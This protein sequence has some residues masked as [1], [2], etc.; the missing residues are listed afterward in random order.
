MSPVAGL[1]PDRGTAV[2][3]LLRPGDG[4]ALGVARLAGGFRWT[5]PGPAWVAVEGGAGVLGLDGRRAEVAGRGDLFDGPGWSA[6]A[7]PGAAVE[8]AGGLRVALVWR[9][10]GE[11]AAR[12][13]APDEV[14]T[15]VRG[16]GADRRVVRTAVADGPLRCGETLNDPGCWSSW[17]P[18][19]HPEEEVYLYRCR[20][21]HGFGIQLRTGPADGPEAG[22]GVVVRDG[23]VQRITAGW[24]PVVAAP[25]TRLGYLW[26]IAAGDGEVATETDVRL[27]G[28]GGA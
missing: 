19:R 16:A 4:G 25:G 17:P 9:A 6:L 2:N 8:A 12:L 5:P 23:D 14:E 11:V 10:A 13:I 20:P 21:A 18:H 3:V 1:I 24:H 15:A 22:R 7:G 26:V 28:D 27:G